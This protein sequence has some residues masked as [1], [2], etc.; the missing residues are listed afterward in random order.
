MKHNM[1]N[2]LA[3]W[4]PI[5][6]SS[7][8]MMGAYPQL[9]GLLPYSAEISFPAGAFQTTPTSVS[10]ASGMGLSPSMFPYTSTHFN[11]VLIVLILP[12]IH[13]LYQ[14]DLL[15]VNL[16]G[17]RIGSSKTSRMQLHLS[18]HVYTL[19]YYTFTTLLM[20]QV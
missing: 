18:N 8:S 20:L 5:Y 15:L 3:N 10:Q 19:L 12:V 16:Q 11:Q 14:Q 9:N 13:L 6:T 1:K 7:A 17:W 4:Q 2:Q